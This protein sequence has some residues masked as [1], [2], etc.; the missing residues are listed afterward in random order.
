MANEVTSIFREH[1]IEWDHE[2]VS[3]LWNYYSRTPPYSNVIFLKCM[4]NTFKD[5]ADYHLEKR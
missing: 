2:K 5:T 1:D 4:V 3:R